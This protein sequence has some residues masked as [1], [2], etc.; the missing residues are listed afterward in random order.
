M[1]EMMFRVFRFSTVV[2]GVRLLVCGAVVGVEHWTQ[3]RRKDPKNFH[4]E[5][6]VVGI[7]SPPTLM[8]IRLEPFPACLERSP[9]L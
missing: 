8:M 3:Y 4:V 2:G 6:S 1:N 7:S 9:F 5:V